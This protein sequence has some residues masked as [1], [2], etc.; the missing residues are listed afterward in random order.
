M[1]AVI[2]RSDMC[3]QTQSVPTWHTASVRT[4]QHVT[5]YVNTY[6]RTDL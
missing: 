1:G 6:L 2:V 3:G 5:A 4:M